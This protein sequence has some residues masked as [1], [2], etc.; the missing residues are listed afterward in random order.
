[1]LELYQIINIL[2]VII[3]LIATY[4]LYSANSRFLKGEFKNFSNCVVVL[5]FFFL[6]HMVFSLYSVK[7]TYWGIS[8]DTFQALNMLFGCVIGLLLIACALILN[9]FSKKY[10]LAGRIEKPKEKN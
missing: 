10:G 2:G 9:K 3:S 5:S 4:V 8:S 1:M 6:Y 7:A